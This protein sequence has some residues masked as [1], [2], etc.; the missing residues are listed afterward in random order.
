MAD[1]AATT[2]REL[3]YDV[4]DRAPGRGQAP[5][6]HLDDLLHDSRLT[7]GER[8]HAKEL[9]QGILRRQ[10]TVD[11]VLGQ[12]IKRPLPRVE[13]GL[14]NWLRLGAFELLFTK[15]APA[16]AILN[17]TVESVKRMGNP[18]W[19]GFINGVLRTLSRQI[20]NDATS[21]APAA[22][23][24]PLT[25]GQY[26]LLEVTPFP[27]PAT[28]PRGYFR[29]AFSFPEWLVARWFKRF[30]Y[31]RLIE[32]GFWFNSVPL[33][34]LRVNTLV[35][36]RESL[37]LKLQQSGIEAQL[38]DH[39]QAIR[40][41]AT[42]HVTELPGF[43]EGWFAIQDESAML[44]AS[45]LNPKPGERVLDLCAAPG[46]KTLHI[47]ALMQN[48]GEVIAADVDHHRLKLVD[49]SCS[50]LQVTNV[51]SVQIRRE[52]DKLP[53]GPFDAV[54]VDVPCSN[55]GV[56]GKRPE[57]RWRVLPRDLK[58]L[59]T[60]QR[61][62]LREALF[63]VKPSGRV[64]YSTCSIEPEENGD[65]VRAVLSEYRDFTLVSERLSLP[66]EPSDGGYIALL[67]RT[68]ERPEIQSTH[69][70]DSLG[71]SVVSVFDTVT[72]NGVSDFNAE[73]S[74][75]QETSQ[76]DAGSDSEQLGGKTG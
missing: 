2:S 49:E 65:I 66:G 63:A 36:D 38:G 20:A 59:A 34:T 15:A 55:T 42:T 76:H 69:E 56:L 37:M 11:L 17:E 10:P 13:E 73:Q 35:T 22:N 41:S 54:L 64:V 4:L 25:N 24:L 32:L 40:L 14:L 28:D 23:A 68:S 18:Q 52:T 6:R 26:R 3:A 58:E 67:Q 39:S 8:G 19:A 16:Y 74:D 71:E 43:N 57:V 75:R 44:V 60:I 48:Q 9:V 53:K 50:R 70:A 7:P 33:P 30:S 47:A 5:S 46:G 12:L 51:K 31:D 29:D 62:L 45:L 72:I 21:T 61:R 1:T 27:S